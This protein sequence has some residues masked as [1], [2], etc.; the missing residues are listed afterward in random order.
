[1]PHAFGEEDLVKEL[2]DLDKM[3]IQKPDKKEIH[4]L[5][6]VHSIKF[7]NANMTI[8]YMNGGSEEMDHA[9]YQNVNFTMEADSV[10]R[11]IPETPTSNAQAP[12]I[13]SLSG[14]VFP[15]P[16][17]NQMF[18][19]IPDQEKYPVTVSVFDLNGRELIKKNYYH[20]GKYAIPTSMLK[21][22]IYVCRFNSASGNTTFKIIKE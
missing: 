11:V 2:W 3:N 14:S 22:G 20:G 9:S 10:L 18:V 16:F 5:A 4:P 17:G 21:S 6:S 12:A 1:M 19:D 15:N 7:D 8:K 13:S